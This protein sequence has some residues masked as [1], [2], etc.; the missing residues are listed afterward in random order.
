LR[1]LALH[2][3]NPGSAAAAAGFAPKSYVSAMIGDA[4]RARR[5]TRMLYELHQPVAEEIARCL[6][7]RGVDRFMDLGGGSGVVSLA[8][9]RRH[10]GCKAVVVDI[11]AV[12]RAGR[13]IAHETP[14][15]DRI[16]FYPADF[17]NDDLPGDFDLVLECDVG[18]YGPDLFGKIHSVLNPEGR[19]VIVDQFAPAV[20]FARP[21]HLHWAFE[22]SLRDPN[23]RFRTAGEI[24]TE[25]DAAAF[26]VVSEKTITASDTTSATFDSGHTIIEARALSR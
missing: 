7:L 4:E 9:L 5:F 10:A 24:C 21:G 12:C 16:S 26:E 11:E 23:F 17:M 15:R 25:L 22:R 1:D 13:E 8:L 3:Q 18:E 20:G 2:I 19:F 14:V 6:D